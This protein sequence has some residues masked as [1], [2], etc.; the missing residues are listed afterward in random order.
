ETIPNGISMI[1]GSSKTI[2]IGMIVI[3]YGMETIPNRISMIPV[4]SKAIPFGIT[5]IPGILTL[6]SDRFK[7]GQNNFGWVEIK[8]R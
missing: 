6:I 8:L 2:P 7:G 1:P 4:G 5:L 3:L